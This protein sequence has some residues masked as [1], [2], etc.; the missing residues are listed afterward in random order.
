MIKPK[1]WSDDERE[2]YQNELASL[3]AILR[4]ATDYSVRHLRTLFLK[5]KINLEPSAHDAMNKL[6]ELETDFLAAHIKQC[7]KICREYSKKNRSRIPH[8]GYEDYV[9]EC[10]VAIIDSVC[11]YNGE[12]K[13]STY[14]QTAFTRRLIEVT[15]SELKLLNNLQQKAASVESLI[16][17]GTPK[18]QA[19]DSLDCAIDR[20]GVRCLMGKS[21]DLSK[22]INLAEDQEAQSDSF[23]L[24]QE[25]LPY[26][27]AQMSD[28]EKQ[29]LNCYMND[30][31]HITLTNQINPNT[32]KLYTRA[33]VSQA[34][35]KL[36]KKLR[37][38][39]GFELS[40]IGLATP[41]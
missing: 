31:P 35:I 2:F 33:A 17:S 18:Q 19:I 1:I 10:A 41:V 21:V 39:M 23:E 3:N 27:I 29:L 37:E 5:N 14:C 26:W 32:G 11:G 38:L 36:K 30:I 15:R 9:Q 7:F 24:F 20:F 6:V 8:M 12:S 13:F 28:F 40:K 4:D 25:K 22:I 16:K 34:F